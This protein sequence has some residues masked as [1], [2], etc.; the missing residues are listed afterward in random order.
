M[1]SQK[2]FV[3]IHGGWHG[4]W[5]WRDVLPLLAAAGHR[6]TAP[7]LTGL[8]ERSH[9]AHSGINLDTHVDD[10]IAHIEMEDLRAVTLVGWSYGGIVAT[11]VLAKI[12]QRI[13]ALVYL[14]SFVAKN[15]Q[16]L[17]D[18]V[19]TEAR[20]VLDAAKA[21]GPLL[22][23]LPLSVFGVTNQ[24]TLDFAGPRLRSQ[25]WQSFYQPVR[26]PDDMVK[27]PTTFVACTGFGETPVTTQLREITAQGD[28][29]IRTAVIETSHLCMLDA[30]AET[31][32]LL[33]AA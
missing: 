17:I 6:A 22:P 33:M 19:P 15:G 20:L 2:T 3:L 8:G 27:V 9:L 25:P 16:A 7:T 11:A 29:G 18:F 4:G 1:S 24:S 26:I 10:V 31:A 28:P 5:V 21:K 30:P 13:A 12:P 23:P 14:D 32:A